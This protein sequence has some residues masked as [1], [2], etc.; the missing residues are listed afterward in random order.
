MTFRGA[1][2]SIPYIHAWL[3]LGL[4]NMF[5]MMLRRICVAGAF[6]QRILCSQFSARPTLISGCFGSS[7][8][9]AS[10]DRQTLAWMQG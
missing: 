3:D 4:E 5:S 8:M 2:A 6:A 10:L 9:A 1:I 7:H